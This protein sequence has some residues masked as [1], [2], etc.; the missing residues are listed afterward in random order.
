MRIF[1]DANMQLKKLVCSKDK[2]IV[3]WGTLYL[4]IEKMREREK[5][6]LKK[7]TKLI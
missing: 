4:K 5:A 1:E 3:Q 2:F 6:C 7:S